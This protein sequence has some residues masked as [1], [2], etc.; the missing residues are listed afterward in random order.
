MTMVMAF[1]G[2]VGRSLA[3]AAA[4]PRVTMR[5]ALVTSGQQ[6][7]TPMFVAALG[8]RGLETSESAQLAIAVETGPIK[9]LREDVAERFSRYARGK[10]AVISSAQLVQMLFEVGVADV[11]TSSV[12][13][14]MN[15]LSIHGFYNQTPYWTPKGQGQKKIY[16]A[17]VPNVGLSECQRYATVF[18]LDRLKHQERASAAALRSAAVEQASAAATI[19]P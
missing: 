5:S 12:G 9:A 19:T 2:V 8:A 6:R 3:A 15:K 13:E 7:R 11:R 16:T 18:F 4:R 10:P 17:P 1:R 14:V